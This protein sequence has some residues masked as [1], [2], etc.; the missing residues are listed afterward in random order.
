MYSPDSMT[1]AER[2]TFLSGTIALVNYIFYF[3][4]ELIKYCIQDVNILRESCL[5]F[6]QLIIEQ[7]DI[8][9]FA[10]CCTIASLTTRIWSKTLCQKGQLV[11]YL[12]ITM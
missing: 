9:L 4:K 3:K 12:R 8:D 6:R 7:V 2:E 1:V 11:F 5:K 10:D